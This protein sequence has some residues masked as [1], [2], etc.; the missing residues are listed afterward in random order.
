VPFSAEGASRA[1]L[2]CCTPPLASSNSR[3][4]NASTMS[5][6]ALDHVAVVCRAA[7]PRRS[8]PALAGLGEG[9][10]LLLS[11]HPERNEGPRLDVLAFFGVRRLDAALPSRARHAVALATVEWACLAVASAKAGRL[12]LLFMLS[13]RTGR[14]WAV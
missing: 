14:T 3:S 7:L 10:P 8:L 1:G 11:C 9:E 6:A 13:F 2:G 5:R 4:E 12:P